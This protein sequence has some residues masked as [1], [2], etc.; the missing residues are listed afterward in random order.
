MAET[1]P[2]PKLLLPF[3]RPFYDAAI[4]LSWWIIRIAVGWNLLVH[5]WDKLMVGPTEALL[6][7]YADIGFNPAAVGFWSSTI[8]ETL[9][10]RFAHP[11]AVHPFL[12]RRRSD[13]NGDHHGDILENRLRLDCGAVTNTRCCGDLCPSPSRCAAAGHTRSTAGSAGSF[14]RVAA[15]RALVSGPGRR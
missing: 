6:K 13:R 4:P 8:L 9:A 5:G 12:R 10:W 1:Q 2:E 11:R 15:A 7:G 14:S 3:L